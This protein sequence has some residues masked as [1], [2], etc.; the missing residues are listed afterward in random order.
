MSAGV[1]NVVLWETVVAVQVGCLGNYFRSFG[2]EERVG[3]GV[4][5]YRR[6]RGNLDVSWR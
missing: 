3:L 4:W 5:V 6:V 2:V 1:T